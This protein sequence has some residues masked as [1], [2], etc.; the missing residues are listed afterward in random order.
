MTDKRG[1]CLMCGKPLV[2]Y[3]SARKMECSICHKTFDNNVSCEDGHYVCDDCHSRKGIE[4][5]RTMCKKSQD[6]NPVI[7]MQ[8]VMADPYIYMHGPEH[9]VLVGAAILTAFHNCGG[10]LDFDWA[11]EEMEARGKEIPGGICGFWGCCGAAV[12]CG[13]AYSILKK[14]TPLSGKSWGASNLMTSKALQA[15]GEA[16]GPRCCK[17]DS[18]LAATAAT[19][20]IKAD[21]GITLEMPKKINCTFSDENEQCTKRA[22]PFYPDYDKKNGKTFIR[23]TPP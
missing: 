23:P 14:S 5:I 1:A 15:I 18:F 2:Y 10:A 6:K 19:A 16:G 12:S 17:R 20:V 4:T 22:C 21:F 3:P 9:H 13:T 8:K 7:L 11:L